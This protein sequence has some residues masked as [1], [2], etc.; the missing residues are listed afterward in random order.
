MDE[1]LRS[2]DVARN[3]LIN[4]ENCPDE[5]INQIERQ[6]S[7]LKNREARKDH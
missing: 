5:E 3:R 6:F 4:L 2:V 1:L 7:A